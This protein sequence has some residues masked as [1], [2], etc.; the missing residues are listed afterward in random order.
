MKEMENTIE[1]I[2]NITDQVQE[3]ICEPEDKLFENT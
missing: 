3:I 1:N 2:S